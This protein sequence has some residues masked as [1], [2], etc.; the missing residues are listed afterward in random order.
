[1]KCFKLTSFYVHHTTKIKDHF[2][3]FLLIK[4]QNLVSAGMG[5]QIFLMT[6][7]YP[8]PKEVTVI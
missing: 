5:K 6:A 1:M 2:P 3:S 8:L 7:L 4:H